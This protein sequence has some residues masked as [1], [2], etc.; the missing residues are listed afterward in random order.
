LS[1]GLPEDTPIMARINGLVRLVYVGE[2]YNTY[3]VGGGSSIE[4]LSLDPSDYRVT[5]TRILNASRGRVD[6]IYTIDFIGGYFRAP[7]SQRV[8]VI[9]DYGRLIAKSVG[10]LKRGDILVSF[11]KLRSRKMINVISEPKSSKVKI[12]PY[13]VCWSHEW[14]DISSTSF[15]KHRELNYSL[16]DE[17]R[18][19]SVKCYEDQL[20][21]SEAIWSS[22]LLGYPSKLSSRGL[23]K[24]SVS[25]ISGMKARDM[26]EKLPTK[27]LH[28]LK[29]II[30]RYARSAYVEHIYSH[31]RRSSVS[32]RIYRLVVAHL[33]CGG[34]PLGF[35][36]Y[37]MLTFKNIVKLALGDIVMVKVTGY[38]RG[39]YIGYV[40]S[41]KTSNGF[42]FAGIYPILFRF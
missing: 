10:S 42:I 34:I 24:C 40:Y 3:M 15:K 23:K 13:I 37:T 38:R 2:L 36:G 22:R 4:V 21:V 29:N 9:D 30:R 19:L 35:E 20:R 41:F 28:K 5:F 6:S 33:L 16:E 14:Y 8:V 11:V 27:P 1:L 25:V 39:D 17:H 31:M 7:E 26:G 12:P 32:K 18:K